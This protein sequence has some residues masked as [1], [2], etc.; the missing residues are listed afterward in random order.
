MEGGRG[1]FGCRRSYTP[2]FPATASSNARAGKCPGA[3][4]ALAFG[5]PCVD[6]ELV[7]LCWS[8]WECQEAP[9]LVAWL[10]PGG[11]E[12]LGMPKAKACFWG[13]QRPKLVFGGAKGQSL[14][15]PGDR[16]RWLGIQGCC[17]V[18]GVEENGPSAMLGGFC[19]WE[20][21]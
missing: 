2:S 18:R 19:A 20:G 11:A 4:N 9:D 17:P 3:K 16:E 13:C 6:E 15:L 8:N 5:F 7:N 21:V 1:C 12:L 10:W 14:F